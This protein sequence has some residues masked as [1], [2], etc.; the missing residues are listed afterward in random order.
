MTKRGLFITFEGNEGS[1]KS[2]QMRILVERLRAEGYNVLESQEPGGSPIGLKIRSLLLDPANHEM[3]PTTEMLLMFAAR[4]QNVDQWIRPALA[5][6]TIVVSDRFTDSTLAYQGAGR[7]LGSE[8]V[9]EVDRVACRGLVPDLT[10]CVDID[11]EEGLQRAHSRNRQSETNETRLDEETVD[12]YKKARAAYHRLAE[13]DGSRFV[14]V[15]GSPDPETVAG[16]V[17][18]V[19]SERLNRAR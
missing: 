6:G 2:T 16:A 19:V 15:D 9:L 12:F 4:A 11:V 18:T 5:A 7:G 17:W 8:V 14:L 10:I 3:S 1:G 13:E